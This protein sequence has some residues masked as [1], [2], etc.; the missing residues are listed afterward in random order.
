MKAFDFVTLA[1]S[2]LGLAVD[3]LLAAKQSPE[4]WMKVFLLLSFAFSAIGIAIDPHLLT[5]L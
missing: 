4:F 2:I 3:I 1:V 5:T